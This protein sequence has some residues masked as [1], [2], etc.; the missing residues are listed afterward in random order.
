[1]EIA[2]FEYVFLPVTHT[3]LNLVLKNVLSFCFY[4]VKHG[5]YITLNYNVCNKGKSNNSC[6]FQDKTHPCD[7]YAAWHDIKI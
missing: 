3:I 7:D 1:M 6:N 5:N 4:F 2:N